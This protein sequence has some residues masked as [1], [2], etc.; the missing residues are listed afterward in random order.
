MLMYNT[1][2]IYLINYQAKAMKEEAHLTCLFIEIFAEAIFKLCVC[3][4][5]LFIAR[6]HL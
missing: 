6:C 3:K 5:K 1:I 4:K 2:V